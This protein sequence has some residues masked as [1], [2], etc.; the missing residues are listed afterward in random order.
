MLKLK[1][2]QRFIPITVPEVAAQYNPTLK[3]LNYPFKEV[4]THYGGVPTEATVTH[5]SLPWRIII[6][7]PVVTVQAATLSRWVCNCVLTARGWEKK[8]VILTINY[9][10][11][12]I[13]FGEQKTSRSWTPLLFQA[14]KGTYWKHP[15]SGLT[16]VSSWAARRPSLAIQDTQFT[17]TASALCD[18]ITI[19][20]NKGQH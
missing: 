8:F 15:L 4:L 1:A 10:S 20:L 3:H 9:T 5:G 6:I 7:L 19:I 16:W 12:F 18:A 2:L 14:L 11:C 13:V 17:F